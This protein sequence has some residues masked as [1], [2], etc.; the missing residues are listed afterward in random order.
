MVVQE[1][2][3]LPAEVT[4]SSEIHA[5]VQRVEEAWGRLDVLFNNAGT[6]VQPLPLEEPS[7]ESGEPF[8]T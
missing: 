1:F 7:L 4:K 2:S 3:S 5:A 6:N 8:S